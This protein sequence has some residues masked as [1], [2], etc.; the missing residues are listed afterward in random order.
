MAEK[1]WVWQVC[2]SFK[3]NCAMHAGLSMSV[4]YRMP[5]ALITQPPPDKAVAEAATPF[6]AP[7]TGDSAEGGPQV[8]VAMQLPR[9][10]RLAIGR[11]QRLHLGVAIRTCWL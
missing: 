11:H 4:L 8:G 6:A 3:K 2:G 10:R 7:V 5:M 1:A 9:R